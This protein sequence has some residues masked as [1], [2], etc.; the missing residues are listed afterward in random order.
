MTSGR[1]RLIVDFDED[2]PADLD[3][4]DTGVFDLVIVRFRFRYI[5]STNSY[6]D[7]SVDLLEASWVVE[8]LGAHARQIRFW[9]IGRAHV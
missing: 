3:H 1:K 6:L 7:V 2:L 5:G 4:V 8:L 9:E